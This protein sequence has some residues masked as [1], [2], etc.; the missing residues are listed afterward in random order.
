M[1]PH[2]RLIIYCCQAT[3]AAADTFKA[4]SSNSS[5]GDQANK[6]G[7]LTK[8][9]LSLRY[10]KNKGRPINKIKKRPILKRAGGGLSA[11][12]RFNE[13]GGVGGGGGGGAVRVKLRAKKRK[14][15]CN[16]PPPPVSAP[17]NVSIATNTL[18][19]I[20]LNTPGREKKL[21]KQVNQKL[22]YR[23]SDW[24]D[25]G[26]VVQKSKETRYGMLK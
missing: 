1:T 21:G 17:G 24:W 15:F 6:N 12:A 13:R 8:R 5:K 22:L 26:L 16:P 18:S 9:T 25:V 2:T 23:E 20:L 4:G 3:H 19:H 7:S 10:P 11:F 14:Y